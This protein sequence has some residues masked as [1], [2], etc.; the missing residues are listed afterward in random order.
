M[1]TYLIHNENTL[2]YSDDYEE[3]KQFCVMVV[4]A[5]DYMRGGEPTTIDRVV[6][7][8]TANARV[9]TK[10]DFEHFNTII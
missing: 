10:E 1:N 6:L 4:M 7:V 3:G 8:N 5:V 2:G 9:A